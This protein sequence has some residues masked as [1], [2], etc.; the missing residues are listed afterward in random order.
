MNNDLI[1]ADNIET[2]PPTWQHPVLPSPAVQ[3]SLLITTNNFTTPPQDS[4][5]FKFLPMEKL[6][7]VA[8]V[9][10]EYNDVLN[11]F[12]IYK[13]KGHLYNNDQWEYEWEPIGSF[14]NITPEAQEQLLALVYVNYRYD[15]STQ[16]TLKVYGIKKSGEED[17]LCNIV[18]ISDTVF[19]TAVQNLQDQIDAISQGTIYGGL[20]TDITTDSEN[21][22]HVNVRYDGN[23]FTVDSN[24]NLKSNLIDDTSITD[25]AWS[26]QQILDYMATHAMKYKGSVNDTSFLPTTADKND[27][28]LCTSE[29]DLFVNISNDPQSANWQPF[30]KIASTVNNYA[31]ELHKS[32]NGLYAQL[33]YDNIDF[34][35]D[36]FN[37]LKSQ[38]IDDT[39][40]GSSVNANKKTYSIVKILQLISQAMHYK[41][42]VATY[43][44]LP[45]TGN[46]AGDVWNVQDTGDNYAWNGTGWDDLSGEY[47]AGAG[48]VITG[49]TISATGISFVVGAGLQATGSGSTTTLLTKNGNGIEYD[50]GNA[51]QVKKGSGI[52]VNANGVNVNTGNTT[53]L[54]NDNIE[55]DYSDG[56]TQDS[57]NKLAVDVGDGIE[58][59][60][61]KLKICTNFNI[62][63]TALGTDNSKISLY[64]DGKI[65]VDTDAVVLTQELLI[66]KKMPDQ[67]NTDVNISIPNMDKYDMYIIECLG[68]INPE[69]TGIM[70]IPSILIANKHAN[71]DVVWAT[72]IAPEFGYTGTTAPQNLCHYGWRLENFNP[73]TNSIGRVSIWSLNNVAT[74]TWNAYAG[75]QG[76]VYWTSPG[77]ALYGIKAR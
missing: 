61:N 21:K 26:A 64:T 30:T 49:K 35:I 29:Y 68:G 67:S 36:N 24:N 28:Y 66:K 69:E 54:V 8:N 40:D 19:N 27:V 56:L 25:K 14:E 43:T 55:V 65:A 46:V 2:T 45:A 12:T 5:L 59:A 53:K 37:N 31:I 22:K 13:A 47:I 70:L 3:G 60:T 57:N 39:M 44:D 7:G 9:K 38:L 17:L 33:R 23:D 32:A 18:F 58:I 48:I 20:A 63:S 6:I 16:N 4:S 76:P 75:Y 77:F 74:G 41:G 10:M 11:K 42:Q 72:G 34:I 51:L 1:N 15:T 73:T 50:N 62:K 71:T 52:S